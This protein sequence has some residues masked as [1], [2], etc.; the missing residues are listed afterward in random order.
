MC[1]R[2]R[3]GIVT[4]ALR[5]RQGV[6][7]KDALDEYERCAAPSARVSDGAAIADYYAHRARA[8]SAR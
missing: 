2:H 7:L 5:K 3:A 4:A 1:A 6:G 8:G